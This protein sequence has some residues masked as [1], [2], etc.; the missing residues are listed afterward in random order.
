[1]NNNID[2]IKILLR[3]GQRYLFYEQKP[4]EENETIFRANFVILYEKSKTLIINTSET[5]RWAKTQVSIPFDWIT[6]IE[7]LED[8]TCGKS[9]L[10][11]EIL[12][13]IDGYI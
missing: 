13:M 4:Y 8:I 1:M 12:L 6:K 9:V 3:K 7:T 10:P 5:E 11:E 2:K